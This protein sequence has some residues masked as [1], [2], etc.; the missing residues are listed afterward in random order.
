MQITKELIE[1][2]ISE[3]GKQKEQFIQNAIATEGAIQDNKFW[4]EWFTTPEKNEK[5]KEEIKQV[6]KTK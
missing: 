6:K 5:K 4:L 1:Q 2:R 3:L